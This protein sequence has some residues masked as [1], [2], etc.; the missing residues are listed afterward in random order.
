[1]HCDSFNI[2][3]HTSFFSILTLYL[4]GNKLTGFV[5]GKILPNLNR[6]SLN[7]NEFVGDFIIT[8]EN[9]P[10][11]IRYLFFDRNTGLTSVDAD[12]D[13]VEDLKFLLVYEIEGIT[14]K[15]ELCDRRDAGLTIYPDT[16]CA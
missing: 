7:D 14:V 16:A 1:M 6:L 8:A 4:G 11:S 12:S 3:N 15:K 10:V 13:A 2:E 9:F 5:G